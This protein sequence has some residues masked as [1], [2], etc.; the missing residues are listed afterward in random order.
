MKRKIITGTICV[1]FL[2]SCI[3]IIPKCSD[4]SIRE[5]VEALSDTEIIVG[6]LCAQY[7]DRACSSLG[8]VHENYVRM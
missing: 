6:P 2:V 7:K 3:L 1:L 5:N 4:I 8:E